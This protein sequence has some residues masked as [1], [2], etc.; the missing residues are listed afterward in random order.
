MK[1]SRYKRKAKQP[2]ARE[3]GGS[4]VMSLVIIKCKLIGMN[5]KEDIKNSPLL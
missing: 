2:V 4:T 3:S 1:N 5:L